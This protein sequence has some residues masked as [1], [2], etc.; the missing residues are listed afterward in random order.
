MIPPYE[1]NDYL[2]TTISFVSD[3]Y[4]GIMGDNEGNAMNGSIDIGIG[5]LPVNTPQQATDVLNKI[6][7][8]SSLN[9]STMADWRNTVTF[10]ADDPNENLH[11]QQAERLADTV[12]TKYPVF[13]IKKIYNDA[14]R[15]SSSPSGLR[16]P[17]CEKAINKAV[18]EG[19]AVFSY[20]GH[21]G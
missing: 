19:T 7:R 6:K 10:V 16:S 3:D 8:Y 14:Y 1:S 17:D 2:I 5:R 15:F 21:G 18:Q 4:F 9:D 11:M 20:T 12:Q 13:N